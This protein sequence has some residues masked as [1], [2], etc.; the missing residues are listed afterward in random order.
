MSDSPLPDLTSQPLDIQHDT[1]PEPDHGLA[2]RIPHVGHT[3]LFFS[4]VTFSIA[5]CL[6]AALGMV[7]ATSAETVAHHPFAAALGQV[8]GYVL[9]FLIAVPLFPSLWTVTFWQGIHWTPRPARLHWWKLILL[10]FALSGLA[11]LADNFIHSPGDSDVLQ[12]FSTPLSAWVT[13]VLGT[14][15]PSFVEEVAF[16]GFLLP[17]LATAYDWLAL[18]RK[19]EALQRWEQ[20][21]N[22]TLPGWIFAATFSSLAFTALHGFQIHWAKGPLAVLFAVSLVFCAVRIHYRSVAASTLVHMA[23]DFLIFAEMV[24]ATG[25]FRHL[26]KLQ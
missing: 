18:E 1:D 16:R 14:F 22:H 25:G 20:T 7:H 12:L 19:P 24:F 8:A 10:G 6:I 3:L 13:V 15:I 17:S 26:E 21:T 5:L 4:I 9:T 2:R 11:Q 23:Y